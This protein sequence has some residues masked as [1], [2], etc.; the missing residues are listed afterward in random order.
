M[1]MDEVEGLGGD[2]GE[3]TA[4][5]NGAAVCVLRAGDIRNSWGNAIYG[6]GGETGASGLLSF[7]LVFHLHILVQV[8][9][10]SILAWKVRICRVTSGVLLMKTLDI[11]RDVGIVI[12]KK[13][14]LRR[15]RNVTWAGQR[16]VPL[17]SHA[18]VEIGDGPLADA[19]EACA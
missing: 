9:R 17:Q 14:V 4:F 18:V 6:E 8:T 15:D 7:H 16:L 19:A 13:V 5:G 10:H 12:V 1:S 11:R 3:G 2:G